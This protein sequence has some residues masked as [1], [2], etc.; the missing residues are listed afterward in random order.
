MRV[1]GIDVGARSVHAVAV[2]G[3]SVLDARS[4]PSENLDEVARW[5]SGAEAVSIDSPDCWSSTPHV[6]DL[7]LPHKFR[8]A[9]CAEIAL[10]RAAGIW[11]AWATP[12]E[13]VAG[14][15][16]SVGISLFS[17]LRAAGHDPL[18]VYPYA[19]FRS[20]AGQRRLPKKQTPLGRAAR[21]SLLASAG[22]RVPA[23]ME[24][25]HDLLDAAAA[26]LVAQHHTFGVARRFTCGHDGSAIWLPADRPL[27]A[28]VA[29]AASPLGRR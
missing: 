6:E 21:V 15:W 26:A 25:S 27:P 24:A 14:S 1:V 28:R 17:A 9:R 19:A 16:M 23:T 3:R 5:A 18:E 12:P 29:E 7:A 4:F 2:D 10:G 13:P 8:T 20:L 22:L 11:V